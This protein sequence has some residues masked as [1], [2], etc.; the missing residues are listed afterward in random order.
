MPK[1]KKKLFEKKTASDHG[2]V[3]FNSFGTPHEELSF[4]ASAFQ[5]AARHLAQRL[6]DDS[7]FGAH[8]YPIDWFKAAPIVFTYRH[9]LELQLKSVIKEGSAILPL[10][11]EPSI[12]DGRVYSEHSL[13]YL[14][15][16]VIRIA[17]TF[18]WEDKLLGATA[19]KELRSVTHQFDEIDPNGAA[20][21]YPVTTKQTQSVPVNFRF[22]LFAFCDRID[23]LIGDLE[24]L[25]FAMNGQLGQIRELM[26]AQWSESY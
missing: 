16:E 2:T 22:D 1:P 5:D 4:Y 8:G 20:F 14:T 6:R 13:G 15:G 23:P 7:R 12:D 10:R 9:A 21:R 26:Q 3:T 25:A 11:G 19:L 24:S 18:G 17:K